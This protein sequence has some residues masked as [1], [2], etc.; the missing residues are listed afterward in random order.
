MTF[1]GSGALG[2]V[3]HQQRREALAEIATTLSESSSSSTTLSFLSIFSSCFS[4]LRV[5]RRS[6][7]LCSKR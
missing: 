1:F 5:I 4:T 6:R 2:A 7:Y 3:V